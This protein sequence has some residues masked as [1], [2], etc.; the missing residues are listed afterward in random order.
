MN[1]PNNFCGL[2]EEFSNYQKSKVVVLPVP[3]DGTRTWIVGKKWLAV[4]ASK[5]PEG[6]IAASQNL[7]L[8]DIELDETPAE[9]G[10]HT[11]PDLKVTKDPETVINNIKQEALRHLAQDKF[12]VM[13]GG[14]H[15]ISYGLYLALLEK[16]TDVS[17]VQIDA[18]SDLR[19]SFAGTKYSHASVM[20]RIRETAKQVVQIG[21][22]S[23]S[24]E[25][26]QVIKKKKYDIFYAHE[27]YDNKKWFD[28]AISKLG[29]NVFV[30]IDIDGLDISTIPATGTPEPGGLDWYLVLEFLKKLFSQRN[31][32]GFDVVE[33]AP[34]DH[35]TAADFAAA[36]LV[37]KLIGYKYF[38]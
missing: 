27:I 12:M 21:I 33:L 18:H 17:V 16:Y 19:E 31:V 8:Y 13:L 34:N 25:E 9:I 5:G 7:E 10:I 14:E 20:A 26:A 2:Q 38:L 3:Y 35:S 24:E 6:I 1:I 32:V 37:Y 36:K 29:K 22:R 28:K 15:S 30:T 11:L 23:M 4:D